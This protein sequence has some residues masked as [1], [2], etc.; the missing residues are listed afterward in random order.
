MSELMMASKD[1]RHV[2]RVEA[3]RTD[4]IPE[5]TRTYC[6]VT[7]RELV[8]MVHRISEEHGL[9]LVDEKLGLAAKNM[10]MFGTYLIQGKDF[11]NNQIQMMLGIANSYDKSLAA[12]ICWGQSIIVCSNLSFCA[13]GDETGMKS[14]VGH[15]HTNMIFGG[16]GLNYRLNKSLELVDHF[17]RKQERFCERLREQE[18]SKE[19]AY[20][21]V[22]ESARAGVIGKTNIL[23]ICDLWNY[24]TEKHPDTEEEYKNDWHEE[25]RRKDCYSLFNCFTE[26]NKSRL[27][28]NMV[29]A[30]LDT[31][32]LTEFFNKEFVLN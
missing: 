28:R 4:I 20:L 30:S 1:G 19:K 5:R 25:F 21:T 12:K 11:F 29:S 7:N 8:E 13:Y 9:T 2:T 22:V 10:R 16:D 32:K 27:E 23:G 15:K 24:Q 18:L 3:F 26:S 17:V 31:L 6:P 14:V